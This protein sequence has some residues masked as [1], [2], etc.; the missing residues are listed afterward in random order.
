MQIYYRFTDYQTVTVRIAPLCAGYQVTAVTKKN[1]TFTDFFFYDTALRVSVCVF[2]FAYEEKY[3]GNFG[4]LVTYIN[5][6]YS[7]NVFFFFSGYQKSNSL[8]TFRA[9]W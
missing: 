4:N 9:F 7:Y 5:L 1:I 8:V 2:F 6:S 3:I